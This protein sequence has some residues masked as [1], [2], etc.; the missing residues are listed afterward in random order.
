MEKIL[1]PR[2]EVESVKPAE[3]VVLNDDE[4]EA[5]LPVPC[6]HKLLIALPT[7]EKTFGGTI[8]KAKS[9]VHAETS[10]TVIAIVLDMGPDAYADKERFPGGPWCKKG[11]YVLLAPYSGVRFF[12]NGDEYRVIN[13]DSISGVVASPKGYSS[14]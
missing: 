2:P 7:V 10:T 13:D 11:D 1:P 12:L 9:T 8:I 14:I 3:Y 4:L 6:G 5:A